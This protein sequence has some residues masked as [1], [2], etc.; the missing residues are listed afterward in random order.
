MK[1]S[2]VLI[3]V[4]QMWFVLFECLIRT[5]ESAD[6]VNFLSRDTVNFL[7]RDTVNFLS[8]DTVNFLSLQQ[9]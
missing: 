3:K 2:V 1:W 6:T 4:K 8:R 7:S 9:A 5:F